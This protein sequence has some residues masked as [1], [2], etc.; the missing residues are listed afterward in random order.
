MNLSD[1]PAR[2]GVRSLSDNYSPL[3]GG[4]GVKGRGNFV[5]NGFD[6]VLEGYSDFTP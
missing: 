3:P 5:H 1:Q 4:R 2:E 6:R